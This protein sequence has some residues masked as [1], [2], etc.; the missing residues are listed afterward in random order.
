MQF[1]VSVSQER[2][3]KRIDFLLCLNDF[4]SWSFAWPDKDGVFFIISSSNANC[5]S[6][7]AYTSTK[8]ECL[9]AKSTAKQQNR[10]RLS[11][12]FTK[13]DKVRKKSIMKKWRALYVTAFASVIYINIVTIYGKLTVTSA[14][15][16]RANVGRTMLDTVISRCF[17]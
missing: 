12:N 16:F 17:L 15:Q 14:A 1:T 5:L 4:R 8:R 6:S 10:R 2:R 7:S 3:T 13:Y 11:F 9:W